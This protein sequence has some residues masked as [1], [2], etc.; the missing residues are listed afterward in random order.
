[1]DPTWFITLRGLLLKKEISGLRKNSYQP[2]QNRMKVIK[3]FI[4]R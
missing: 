2:I 3:M 4:N 1:M